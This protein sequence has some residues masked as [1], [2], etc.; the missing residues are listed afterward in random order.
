MAD[1]RWELKP[2]LELMLTEIE[3]RERAGVVLQGSQNRLQV[4]LSPPGPT[5]RCGRIIRSVV[6]VRATMNLTYV[7]LSL[8]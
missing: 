2:I 5:T 7:L 4:P 6:I 3:A 8:D 1:S